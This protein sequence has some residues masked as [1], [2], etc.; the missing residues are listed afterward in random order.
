MTRLTSEQHS[1]GSQLSVHLVWSTQLRKQLAQHSFL[2]TTGVTFAVVA[3][4]TFR[5]PVCRVRTR[6]S[7]KYNAILW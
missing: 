3:R 1:E 2:A 6:V 5:N 4:K 7:P